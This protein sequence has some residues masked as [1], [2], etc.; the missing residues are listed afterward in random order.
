M[1]DQK[2]KKG[3]DFS[4]V[5]SAL[6]KSIRRGLEEDAM[7]W[8][9]ELYNSGFGEY[10]WKRLIIITSED[11]GLAEPDMPTQIEALYQMYVRQAKKTKNSDDK[12]APERLFLTHAIIKLCR[13]KKSRFVDWALIYHFETHD[14][15]QKD[16]PD[17]ALDKHTQVGRALKRKWRHFFDEGC[18]LNNHHPIEGED[19]YKTMVEK[20]KSSPSTLFDE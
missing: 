1:Y 5:A 17:Y 10:L 14:A 18:L 6:Q 13:A 16:I 7:Y 15:I 11:V 19:V 8:A 20:V 3:Y 9:V 2:T 4:Q 12:N